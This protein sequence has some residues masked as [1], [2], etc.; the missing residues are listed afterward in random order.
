MGNLQPQEIFMSLTRKEFLSSV[1][2]AVA[3]VT[4]AAV[5]LGC[6]DNGGSPDAALP[7]CPVNG[8]TPLIGSNHAPPINHTISVPLAD[9]MAGVDKMYVIQGNATHMHTLTVTAADFAIL[10]ANDSKAIRT[11]LTTTTEAHFHTIVL[12]CA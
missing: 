11:L 3:G 2:T 10:K 12:S 7:S 6:S 5:L 4:G 8:V 1:V 9:V